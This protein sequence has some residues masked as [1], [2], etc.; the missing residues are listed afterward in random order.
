MRYLNDLP[1]HSF[2]I[3]R[4]FVS[5]GGEGLANASIVEMLMVLSR[6]LGL[7]VVAEGIETGSQWEQLC[8]LGCIY[9]QGHFF[10]PAV[11]AATFTRMLEANVSLAPARRSAD[12]AC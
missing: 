11:D 4:S 10:A 12:I 3:D 9:G 1:L 2:K 7:D 6:S 8:D 5:N